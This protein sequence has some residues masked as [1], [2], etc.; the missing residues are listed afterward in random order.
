[1]CLYFFFFSYVHDPWDDLAKYVRKKAKTTLDEKI[2][3]VRKER[4]NKEKVKDEK[5][6]SS[7]V[8][9]DI[10]IYIGTHVIDFL[11][12]VFVRG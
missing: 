2:S 9:T 7:A 11:C 10:C 4:K 6:V 1:M 5:E 3:K 8:G 12:L